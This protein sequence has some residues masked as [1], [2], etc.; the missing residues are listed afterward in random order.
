MAR[1]YGYITINVRHIFGISSAYLQHINAPHSPSPPHLSHTHLLPPP[2]QVPFIGCSCTL[3]PT[4]R[5]PCTS[6]PS[7]PS[8]TLHCVDVLAWMS[9]CGW[10]APLFHAHTLTFPLHYSSPPHRR[11]PSSGGPVRCSRQCYNACPFPLLA[12][13]SSALACSS[14]WRIRRHRGAGEQPGAWVT[15]APHFPPMTAEAQV[16]AG[17]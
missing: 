16:P 2:R 11:C 4:Q 13:C 17:D 12:F 14:S 7:T 6:S 5:F 1:C 9:L 8:V 10:C 3:F 15:L